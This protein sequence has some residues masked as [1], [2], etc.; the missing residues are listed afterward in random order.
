MAGLEEPVEMVSQKVIA[1][2]PD[3]ALRSMVVAE[4]EQIRRAEI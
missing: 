4:T 3:R 2:A 1:L